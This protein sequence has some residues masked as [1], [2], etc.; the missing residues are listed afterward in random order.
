MGADCSSMS[1]PWGH[2]PC[3]QTCSSKGSSLFPRVQRSFQEP[4]TGLAPH[5]VMAS[6]GNSPALGLGCSM[7]CSSEDLQWEATHCGTWSSSSPPSSLTSALQSGSSHI[8]TPLFQLLMH[9]RLFSLLKNIFLQPFCG[10]LS[11]GQGGSILEPAGLGSVG[12]GE[13]FQQLLTETPP[14]L[15]LLPKPGQANPIH[16]QK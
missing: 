11:L 4:S 10:G 14:K 6:F 12:H 1:L 13:S 9:C 7:G 2:E 8:G 16:S 5:R 3:Q 15:L